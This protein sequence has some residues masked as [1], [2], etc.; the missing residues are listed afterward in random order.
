MFVDW[1]KN[2]SAMLV[3]VY[4]I[5]ATIIIIT[6]DKMPQNTRWGLCGNRGETINHITRECSK[7]AQRE[8]KTRYDWMGKVIQ[9]ELCKN[10]K[11]DH[12]NKW[13]TKRSC[14]IVPNHRMKIK[15]NEQR[16]KYLDVASVVKTQW[17]M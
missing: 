5:Y 2:V 7:L 14:W 17:N 4:E 11:F 9:W 16:D 10:L 15:E 3:Y 6:I 12:T 1:F 13:Y 8:Y